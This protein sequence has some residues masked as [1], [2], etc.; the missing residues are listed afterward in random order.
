MNAKRKIL[1][2]AG[3]IAI[4]LII[5]AVMLVVGRGHTVYLDNKSLE[6]NGQTYAAPYKAT[7][8]KGGEQ[9]AKLYDAERGKAIC[10]GQKFTITLE[11][12]QT[13]GGSEQTTTVTIRL[14]YNMDGIILNLPAVL[15]GLPEEAYMTEFIST[16]PEPEPE[17]EPEPDEVLPDDLVI[18]ED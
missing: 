2:R 3:A 1:F 8:F 18:P 7:V 10:I 15:A 17:P 4:L 13:K 12:T 6:Y 11:I 16:Q 14:P 9:V 5:G